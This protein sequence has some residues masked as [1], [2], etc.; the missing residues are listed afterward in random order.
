[1]IRYNA[2]KFLKSFF[3]LLIFGSSSVFGMFL[4]S[5]PEPEPPYELLNSIEIESQ[6]YTSTKSFKELHNNKLDCLKEEQMTM[7]QCVENN[8]PQIESTKVKFT[9][10]THNY[11]RLVNDWDIKVSHA[12]DAQSL[13]LAKEYI[14]SKEAGDIDLTYNQNGITKTHKTFSRSR[15]LESDANAVKAFLEG[16]LVGLACKGEKAEEAKLEATVTKAKEAGKDGEAAVFAAF[17]LMAYCLINKSFAHVSKQAPE[18][19][20]TFFEANENTYH[21][22]RFIDTDG[23]SYGLKI[24]DSQKPAYII[25]KHHKKLYN[26]I[27]DLLQNQNTDLV[28]AQK[29][30]KELVSFHGVKNDDNRLVR[31]LKEGQYLAVY[32]AKLERVELTNKQFQTLI[33]Y[34]NTPKEYYIYA[35]RQID[36]DY[37]LGLPASGIEQDILERLEKLLRDSG[38]SL[39]IKPPHLIRLSADVINHPRTPVPEY[40]KDHTSKLNIPTKTIDKPLSVLKRKHADLKGI[41]AK[42]KGENKLKAL[43]WYKGKNVTKLCR[44][45]DHAITIDD[46]LQTITPKQSEAEYVENAETFGVRVACFSIELNLL[47]N[48][49]NQF[50]LPDTNKLFNQVESPGRFTQLVVQVDCDLSNGAISLVPY[51]NGETTCHITRDNQ[52]VTFFIPLKPDQNL[53]SYE[54]LF[55]GSNQIKRFLDQPPFGSGRNQPNSYSVTN[56]TNMFAYTQNLEHVSVVVGATDLT[57]VFRGSNF[58]GGGFDLAFW[59]VS[60]VTSL[61]ATFANSGVERPILHNWQTSSVEDMRE[62]FYSA[63]NLAI[64]INQWNTDSLSNAGNGGCQGFADNSGL[65][66]SAVYEEDFGVDSAYDLMPFNEEYYRDNC[67]VED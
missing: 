5:A 17:P 33:F 26:D 12:G 44:G 38:K 21:L 48:G 29:K 1:M 4:F 55:Q 46:T 13:N 23:I 42:G 35:P 37:V 49:N 16:G 32:N 39:L 66:T 3:V 18:D 22:F 59:N 51:I 65:F 52:I 11:E 24:K 28:A 61:N 8:W 7:T 6:K 31:N 40:K 25:S 2:S 50:Q 56:Y 14:F 62:T 15:Q 63:E 60:Q 34:K 67:A 47:D 10:N 57:G 41:L 27:K 64:N 43:A 45:V 54:G 36:G 30:F 53:I 9:G 20:D 19:S 58:T